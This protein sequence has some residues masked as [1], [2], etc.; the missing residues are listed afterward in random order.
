MPRVRDILTI[1]NLP[2][3]PHA[4]ITDVPG[5]RVG[6]AS[7]RGGN[8]HTGITAVLPHGGNLYRDKV[9]A[10]RCS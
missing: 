2:A 7:L 5:V 4:A 6:H 10:P 1:G 9:T 3:G 8:L